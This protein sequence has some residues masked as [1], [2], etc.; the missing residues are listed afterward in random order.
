MRDGPAFFVGAGI[1]CLLMLPA[2]VSAQRSHDPCAAEKERE[3]S[4]PPIVLHDLKFELVA[5]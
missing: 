2:H 4:Y 1:A 5:I 3:D